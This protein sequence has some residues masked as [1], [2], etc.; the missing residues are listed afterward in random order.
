[1]SW[2]HGL[3]VESVVLASAV[4]FQSF[5]SFTTIVLAAASVVIAALRIRC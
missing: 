3:S 1:M 2:M 5:L 4:A